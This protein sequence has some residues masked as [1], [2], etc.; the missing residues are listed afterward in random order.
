MNGMFCAAAQLWVGGDDL[1][2]LDFA[3]TVTHENFR[4]SRSQLLPGALVHDL[5][6][7]PSLR[8]LRLRAGRVGWGRGGL[9][10]SL[11]AL[12]LAVSDRKLSQQTGAEVPPSRHRPLGTSVIARTAAAVCCAHAGQMTCSDD[13]LS[14]PRP[15]QSCRC[16]GVL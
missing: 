8:S 11:T 14:K 6:A 13:P 1:Q 7:C 5:G 12:E 15:Q 4:G 3:V 2:H 10:S 9:A 16:P